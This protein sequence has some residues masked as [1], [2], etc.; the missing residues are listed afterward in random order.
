[1]VVV[2]WCD[3]ETVL[4]RGREGENNNKTS[5]WLGRGSSKQGL[6]G[7]RWTTEVGTPSSERFW[8]PFAVPP[9]SLLSLLKS[10]PLGSLSHP[11]SVHL[12]LK[13]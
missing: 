7:G 9:G 2:S 4:E 6:G 3:E 13:R 10:A 11:S 1:M 5:Q 12:E 8:S